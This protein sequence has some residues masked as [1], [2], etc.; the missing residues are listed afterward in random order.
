MSGCLDTVGFVFDNVKTYIKKDK[1]CKYIDNIACSP[2]PCRICL[3]NENG[4]I[5][6]CETCNN[7]SLYKICIFKLNKKNFISS[8][9]GIASNKENAWEIFKSNIIYQKNGNF[10][11]SITN[12]CN[13]S[14]SFYANMIKAKKCDCCESV[15]VYFKYNVI[16]FISGSQIQY[17]SSHPPDVILPNPTEFPYIVGCA[18]KHSNITY[19]LKSG[20]YKTVRFFNSQNYTFCNNS[21]GNAM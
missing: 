18:N 9:L 10:V 17:V 14:H 20:N 2:Q 15:F 19:N 5:S 8:T 6:P 1:L 11:I 13:I 16:S 12:K 21:Y 7:N 4:I 3:I